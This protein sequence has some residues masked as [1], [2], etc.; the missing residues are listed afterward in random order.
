MSNLMSPLVSTA[1]TYDRRV[2]GKMLGVGPGCGSGHLLRA[3]LP[4]EGGAVGYSD[5]FSY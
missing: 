2:D 1:R 4:Y 5:H 3:T